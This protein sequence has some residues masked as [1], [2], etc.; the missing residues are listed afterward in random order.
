MTDFLSRIPH[1]TF[2]VD[3]G[4]FSISRPVNF[5]EISTLTLQIFHQ[6]IL[7]QNNFLLFIYKNCNILNRK[8]K[9]PFQ[10]Q[11][12]DYTHE[13]NP[14]K[15]VLFKCKC[16][17][18]IFTRHFLSSILNFRVYSKNNSALLLIICLYLNFIINSS[19]RFRNCL[20]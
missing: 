5:R 14:Y 12:L 20:K 1:S 2:N 9:M 11:N 8:P 3:Q 16:K 18:L 6:S 4:V 13:R 19:K 7:L 10:F 17:K 15:R